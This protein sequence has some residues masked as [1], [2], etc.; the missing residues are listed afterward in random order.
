MALSAVLSG[1]LVEAATATAVDVISQRTID[2]RIKTLGRA[3][4]VLSLSERVLDLYGAVRVAA[5]CDAAGLVASEIVVTKTSSSISGA[6]PAIDGINFELIHESERLLVSPDFAQRHEHDPSPLDPINYRNGF[7]KENFENQG[8]SLWNLTEQCLE[9]AARAQ[10]T[11]T[12]LLKHQ[13]CKEPRRLPVLGW[14]ETFLDR[15][16][17]GLG[18]ALW[19]PI[20]IIGVG[21]GGAYNSEDYTGTYR[22]EEPDGYGRISFRSGDVYTGQIRRSFPFGYGVMEYS[23]G[24]LFAGHHSPNSSDLGLVL[25]PLRDKAIIGASH[26]GRPRNYCRQ[27]GL[28]NGVSSMSGVW[29]DG[30]FSKE[31]GTQG[32][33]HKRIWENYKSMSNPRLQSLKK[34]LKQKAEKYIEFEKV[35]DDRF[36]GLI[37]EIDYRRMR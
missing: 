3:W 27:I 26:N 4:K 6:I 8:E 13:E 29:H 16:N 17:T 7:F 19:R 15:I 28:S 2:P 12:R 36:L 20:P 34:E 10:E 1:L 31:F 37:S 33:I 23:D 14:E 24:T 32:S 30:E 25:T 9:G 5:Y 18:Y 35:I 11:V 22:R 21:S